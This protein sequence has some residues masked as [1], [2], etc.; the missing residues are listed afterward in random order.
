MSDLHHAED[1][2]RSGHPAEGAEGEVESK[3]QGAALEGGG[4]DV[5]SRNQG[6]HLI[7]DA[8]EGGAQKVERQSTGRAEAKKA[9]GHDAGS[10]H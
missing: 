7:A 6:H 5:G 10:E 2:E 4:Q 8:A 3:G 9:Q 1:E